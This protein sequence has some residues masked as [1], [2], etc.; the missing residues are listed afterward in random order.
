M[1]DTNNSDIDLKLLRINTKEIFF[2]LERFNASKG[3]MVVKISSSVSIDTT[4]QIAGMNH[5]CKLIARFVMKNPDTKK[6][7][8]EDTFFSTIIGATYAIN[9]KGKFDGQAFQNLVD[10]NK[11][12]RKKMTGPTSSWL[13]NSFSDLTQK[14]TGTPVIIKKTTI[15]NNMFK[16]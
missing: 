1:A 9:I 7:T 6:D 5:I 11:E 16:S 14:A 12:V 4:T 10:T 3:K 13:V 8:D 2:N 15:E